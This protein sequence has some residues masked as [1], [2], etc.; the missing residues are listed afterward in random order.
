[1][2]RAVAVSVILFV[3]LLFGPLSNSSRAQSQEAIAKRLA[4]MWRLVSNP[5]RL[6]DGTTREGAN[7]AA[8]AFFD[9]QATHMCFISMNP[10]RP[11]WKSENAPTAEEGLS[12]I[13]GFGAYCATIEIHPKEGFLLRSYEINQSPNAVGR[14]TKRWYTFQGNHRM[15]LRVDAAELNPPVVDNTLIWER[16]GK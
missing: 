7:S 12:A 16:V 14:M 13:R 11:R 10:N 15:T 5:Q 9:A 6:A 3:F 8:Y 1:M 2:K 4:G